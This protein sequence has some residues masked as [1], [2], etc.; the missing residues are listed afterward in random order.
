MNVKYN[1]ERLNDVIKHFCIL[2]KVSV[3]VF[4]SKFTQIAYYSE[5]Q[6]HFCMEIQKNNWG[7]EQCVCSDLTLLRKC[8][9]SRRTAWHICHAGIL[10]AAMPIIKDNVI[11]GYIIIGRTRVLRFEEAFSRIDWLG[12]DNEKMKEYYMELT[13]YSHKQ[14]HSMF[15]LASMIV[16]FILTN[17]IINPEI[18]RF[19][20]NAVKFIDEHIDEK[21]SIEILCKEFNVSKNYL[22]EKFRTN[23]N[24]TVNDYIICRRMQ[25]AS[26]LL[27]NTELSVSCIAEKVG[28]ETYTYFGRLFKDKYN[29]SPLAYRK[30]YKNGGRK[31]L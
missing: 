10:D 13:G 4:D 9:E 28:I 19:S 7:H 25:M 22:Y 29:I 6:P 21:L 8:M 30:T 18:D 11:I 12:V 5:N 16:S 2:T 17:D 31:K 26:E 15:E 27:R 24:S 14:I 20:Q 1:S 3:G 23:L